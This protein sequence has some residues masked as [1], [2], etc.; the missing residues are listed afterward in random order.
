MNQRYHLMWDIRRL[1]ERQIFA[2]QMTCQNM[3]AFIKAQQW[4]PP[5]DSAAADWWK[6][7]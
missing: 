4:Q 3:L 1:H 2:L 5:D 7:G 6:Q